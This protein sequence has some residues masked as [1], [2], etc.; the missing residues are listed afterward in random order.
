MKNIL[1][2][3]AMILAVLAASCG[4]NDEKSFAKADYNKDG[5]VVFEELIVAYP[6]LTVEEYEAFDKDKGGA[7]SEEEYLAFADARASGRKPAPA[8]EAP[9]DAA[10]QTAEQAIPEPP[11][12]ETPDAPGQTAMEQPAAEQPGMGQAADQAATVQAGDQT[13]TSQAATGQAGE[14]PVAEVVEVTEALTMPEGGGGQEEIV[15]TVEIAK[16]EPAETTYEVKRGDALSRVASKFGVSLKALMA[17]NNID[18]PD[19]V[20]AGDKL[21]IPPGG[22]MKSEAGKAIKKDDGKTISGPMADKAAMFVDGFL[23]KSAQDDV[24]GLVE[25]YG[26]QVKF[27]KKGEVDKDFIRKDKMD[28]FT[29]W[30]VREYATA[31][32]V[33]VYDTDKENVKKAVFVSDYMVKNSQKTLSGQAEFT[34]LIRFDGDVGTIVA[35]DGKVIKRN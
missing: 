8:A 33:R 9:K 24:E 22:E 18:N 29:R 31:G 25:M 12:A 14:K 15:E 35:E 34:L 32:T 20:E 10:G 19:H 21:V 16:P 5:K 7:L 13:T 27:Y 2:F 4:G 26:P 1:C 30:P 6:D 3:A 28:Y 17:A 11:S 23:V